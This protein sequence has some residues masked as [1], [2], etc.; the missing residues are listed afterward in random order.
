MLDLM[1]LLV[2]ETRMS[3][4]SQVTRGMTYGMTAQSG[5]TMIALMMDRTIICFC[6]SEATL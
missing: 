4:V 5:D 6:V 1:G 3:P 2:D